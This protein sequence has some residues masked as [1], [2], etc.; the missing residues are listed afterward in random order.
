MR[1]RGLLTTGWMLCCTFLGMADFAQQAAPSSKLHSSACVVRP[2]PPQPKAILLRASAKE[3]SY[4][5]QRCWHNTR[6]S[7]SFLN[8]LSQ[9]CCALTKS[10]QLCQPQVVSK[11]SSSLTSKYET[12]EGVLLTPGLFFEGRDKSRICSSHCDVTVTRNITVSR[13]ASGDENSNTA[14]GIS[15]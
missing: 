14:Q 6:A 13:H 10:Q 5:L 7:I 3:P 11:G 1:R 4:I 12:Q 2:S 8:N 9:K 15:F